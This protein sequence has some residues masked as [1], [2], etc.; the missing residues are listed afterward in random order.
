MVRG[1]HLGRILRNLVGGQEILVMVLPGALKVGLGSDLVLG[2]L[3][4]VVDP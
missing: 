4:L 3:P 1:R 2:Y